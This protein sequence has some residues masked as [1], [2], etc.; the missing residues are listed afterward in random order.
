MELPP[1]QRPFGHES[2]EDG[3]VGYRWLHLDPD[4]PAALLRA[5][6]ALPGAAPLNAAVVATGAQAHLVGGAVRDLLVG[7][8]PRELDVVV[9]GDPAALVEALGGTARNHD[10]FETATVSMADG[11]TID[12]ARSR[13]ETYPEPGAL[14]EVEPAPLAIDLH[15]RDVTFNAIAIDLTTGVVT[16]AGTAIADLDDAILRVLH[17]ASFTDDPTRLWR[18]ARYEVR[19]A[20][21]WEPIT[22]LLAQTAVA[23]GALETVTIQRLA[24]ELRLAL[25]EPDAYGALAAAE[26]LGLWPRLQLDALRLEQAERLGAGLAEPADLALAAFASP[27]PRLARMLDRREESALLDATFLLRGAHGEGR[28]PGPLPDTAPGSL[29]HQRFAGLPA[30]AI[31]AAP[32]SAAA[33]R[34]LRELSEVRPAI[35][36][37]DLLAAGIPAGPALGVALDAARNAVLDGSIGLT[38]RDGQLRIALQAAC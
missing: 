19:M 1:V 37:T 35:D 33:E 34:W 31:A 9:E 12:I 38:D 11:S 36:G 4:D 23:H 15:R 30:A 25:R 13:S 5:I 3:R 16:A 10:R 2:R 22:A 18:L 21:D 20:A 28:R 27:D 8:V 14:P 32:D 24:S 17:P 26:R 29:I 6:A 7:R